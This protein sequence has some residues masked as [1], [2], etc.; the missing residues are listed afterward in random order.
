MSDL[1]RL[2]LNSAYQLEGAAA[3]SPAIGQHPAASNKE[4]TIMKSRLLLALAATVS[5]ATSSGF[6]AEPTPAERAYQDI[7]AT[8]GIVPSHFK[9]YPKSA[10]AGAWEMT[11]GL[12]MGE[13]N[14]LEPKVKSLIAVAVAAQI[15]CSIASG[16]KPRR[17]RQPAPPTPKYRKPWPRPPMCGTG[18]P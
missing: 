12:L 16:S 2:C 10:V 5:L 3:R 18:A 7:E 14:S 4:T 8:L 1:N 17:P 9:A 11:K 15:P 6:A 13:G